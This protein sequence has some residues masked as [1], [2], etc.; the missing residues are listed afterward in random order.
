MRSQAA[1]EAIDT[2]QPPIPVVI[3]NNGL[4]KPLSSQV[5]KTQTVLSSA[6][7]TVTTQLAT[8][9]STTRV[10]FVGAQFTCTATAGAGSAAINDSTSGT[11]TATNG[12]TNELLA[13]NGAAAGFINEFFAPPLPRECVTGLR[14]TV[15]APATGT[16]A[17]I[18]YWIEETTQI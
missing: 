6:G 5:L 17:L 16:S 8:T 7:G 12:A 1:P 11:P 9:T 18:V 10:Y 2:D 15:Q 4:P 14:A 3:L 13:L